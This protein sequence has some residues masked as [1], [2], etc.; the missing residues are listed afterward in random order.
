MAAKNPFHAPRLEAGGSGKGGSGGGQGGGG[1]RDPSPVGL[2]AGGAQGGQGSRGVLGGPTD[3]A[4]GTSPAAGDNFT[5]MENE[6]MDK[7][8]TETSFRAMARWH[9]GEHILNTK[10]ARL[11]GSD[12]S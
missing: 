1:A 11:F 3:G 8:K 9:L 10:T 5:S 2:V 7:T 6:T 4:S 12:S